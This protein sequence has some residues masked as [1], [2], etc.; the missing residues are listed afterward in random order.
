MNMTNFRKTSIN[1][2]KVFLATATL[3]AASVAPALAQ[4]RIVGARYTGSGCP[5]RF[6]RVMVNP[7]GQVLTFRFR[8]YVANA[9]NIRERHKTCKLMFPIRVP[10]GYQITFL[11]ARYQGYVAPKTQGRL[12]A[13]YFVDG[14]PR[15]GL[16][17]M[18]PGESNYSIPDRVSL[19]PWTRCGRNVNMRVNTS[20]TASG[21]SIANVKTI[22]YRIRY[23]QCRV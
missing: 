1:F 19:I 20:M 23:R 4:P 3:L 17:R 9:R 5:R 6:T 7:S 15:H 14:I 22:G 13:R 10:R 21:E 12:R 16:T 18:I 2:V 8:R 11:D